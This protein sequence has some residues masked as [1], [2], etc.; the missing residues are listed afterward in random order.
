MDWVINESRE[1]SDHLITTDNLSF[2]PVILQT[3]DLFITL[4]PSQLKQNIIKVETNLLQ[5]Y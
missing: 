5:R 4:V 1:S 3:V 2:Q